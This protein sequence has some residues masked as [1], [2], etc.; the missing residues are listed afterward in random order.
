MKEKTDYYHYYRELMKNK[1]EKPMTETT[2]SKVFFENCPHL[3]E[4]IRLRKEANKLKE[5][6]RFAKDRQTKFQIKRE[7]N[8]INKKL[9]R[10]NVLKQLH[11]ES[12]QEMAYSLHFKADT[13][14]EGASSLI[15]K[16]FR[17]VNNIYDKIQKQSREIAHRK[18]PP[19]IFDLK[20]LNVAEK[21]L[22]IKEWVQTRQ[23]KS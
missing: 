8:G 9:K 19:S 16:S 4:S 23:K 5:K 21:S 3:A 1:L 15:R 7:L 11:G 10:E 2:E 12:K 6:L 13:A 18:L 22:A 20:S 14:K 17:A